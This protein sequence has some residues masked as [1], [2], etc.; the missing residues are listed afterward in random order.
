MEI[1]PLFVNILQNRSFSTITGY[2]N[3]CGFKVVKINNPKD[4]YN[5]SYILEKEMN[6]VGDTSAKQKHFLWT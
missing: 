2:V 1:W 5:E 6:V 4:E 3:K